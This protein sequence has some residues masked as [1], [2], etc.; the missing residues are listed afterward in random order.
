LAIIQFLGYCGQDG[1]GAPICCDSFEL[2]FYPFSSDDVFPMNIKPTRFNSKTTP[3]RVFA[4]VGFRGSKTR[5]PYYFKTKS[6]ANDFCEELN[7]WKD[8]QKHGAD[9]ILTFEE[10]Q[11]RWMAYLMQ[12]FPDLSVLPDVVSHWKATGPGAVAKRSLREAVE[13]S[14]AYY[15]KEKSD[16]ELTVADVTGKLR[17]FSADFPG[18]A[19]HEV[20][21]QDIKEY[22]ED[23]ETPST[24]NQHIKKLKA[25]FTWTVTERFTA[26]N[27]TENIDF[28]KV[29]AKEAIEFY[30][31]DQVKTLLTT[32]D[33]QFKELLPWLALQFFGFCRSAEAQKLDWNAINF[34]TGIITVSASISKTGKRRLITLSDQLRDWLTPYRKSSGAVVE[35]LNGNVT[36]LFQTAN[37]DRLHNGP[38]HTCC[39][40]A[41][42]ALGETVGLTRICQQAGH[43][44]SI[45][46][47]HYWEALTAEQAAPY[48]LIRR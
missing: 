18:M 47:K 46:R 21:R 4:P 20:T 8:R 30:P 29:E 28:A 32:A 17:N 48:L 25:F 11:K 33:G 7:A 44:P 36:K 24:K 26:I 31:A 13:A 9:S 42:A 1:R 27:P 34:E 3:Q 40:V 35:N 45:A 39:S 2:D 15:A 43:S 14:L 16:N 23:Y 10:S 12:E 19:C 5:K 41:A 6:A 37:V 38:R 22:L